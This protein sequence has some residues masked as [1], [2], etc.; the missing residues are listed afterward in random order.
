MKHS[1]NDHAGYLIIDHTDSPGISESEI[2]ARLKDSTIP[3]PA[4]KK[5]E[6]DLWTC[7]HCQR[8]VYLNSNRTRER[9]TCLHCY[10]YICDSCNVLYRKTGQCIPFKKVLDQAEKSIARSEIR[11]SLIKLTDS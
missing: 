3:V 1:L 4:G 6:T 7:S 5:F 2:P 11:G 9:A 8:G 10:H